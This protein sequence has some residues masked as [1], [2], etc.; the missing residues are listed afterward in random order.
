M[1]EKAC[2]CRKTAR[3]EDEK[4]K[5]LN[6]LSR[7]EGQIRGIKSMVEADAYCVDVLTQAAAANAALQAFNRELLRRHINTCVVRDMRAGKPG[8]DDE[9]ID[10]LSKL[11]K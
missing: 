5:L 6:R 4:K 2:C 1:E 8:A 10:L 11:M 7:I 3:S 9:L